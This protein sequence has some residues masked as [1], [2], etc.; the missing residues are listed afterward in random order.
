M[1][2]MRKLMAV[3]LALVSA[4][5]LSS[6]ALLPIFQSDDFQADAQ[7]QKIAAA[8]EDG[9]R[10]AL[11]ALFSTTALREATDLDDGLDYLL[12]FFPEGDLRW[13]RDA[14]VTAESENDH[15]LKTN[16]L[17]ALYKVTADG[18]DYWLFFAAFTVNDLVDP[19]NVGIYALGV[20][21]WTED[22]DSVQADSFF[23]WAAATHIRQNEPEGYPGVYVPAAQ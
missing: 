4:V 23:T 2:A 7:M 6:C 19:D 5:A 1:A 22:D 13:E 11:R 16:L 20:T 12:A 9:D 3:A 18:K 10:E 17:R 15:E 14:S 8:L 21:P